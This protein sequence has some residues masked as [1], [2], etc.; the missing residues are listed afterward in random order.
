[1]PS[2]LEFEFVGNYWAWSGDLYYMT[3]GSEQARVYVDSVGET[4][5]DIRRIPEGGYFY[6]QKVDGYR[7]GSAALAEP[8]LTKKGFG[9]KRTAIGAHRVHE[10]V[11]VEAGR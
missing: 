6:T 2:T 4:W 11:I 7:V 5:V 9:D 10:R 8:Y 3:R 1:M